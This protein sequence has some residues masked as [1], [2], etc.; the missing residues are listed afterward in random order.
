[1]V[2][3]THCS[4][5]Y[6]IL[7]WWLKHNLQ[8]VLWHPIISF[9]VNQNLTPYTNVTRN[10][11]TVRY[12]WTIQ[13]DNISILQA[14]IETFTKAIR[15]NLQEYALYPLLD[16]IVFLVM[17]EPKQHYSVTGHYTGTNSKDYWIIV[18]K[19]CYQSCISNMGITLW[20][21]N[22]T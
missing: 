20:Q 14:V 13:D 1:M 22:A 3:L 8:N 5:Y 16:R 19:M 21:N 17:S 15:N 10:P 18:E 11:G 9:T 7:R 6:N 2:E 12:W 4:A